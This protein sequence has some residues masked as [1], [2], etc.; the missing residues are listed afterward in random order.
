[1]KIKKVLLT[2]LMLA[3]I[4]PSAVMAGGKK[5][6]D[7]GELSVIPKKTVTLTVY[8]QLANYSGEQVG[9]FA[10][11]M[12]DKFNV[13]LNI[14]NNEEGIF[15]TR[16]A[17]GD[18]GDIVIFGS[19]TDE[20][21]Q[22]WQAGLLWEWNDENLLEDYGP[23]IADNMKLPLE[24]NASI[25]GGNLYGFAH[26]VA[27][28]ADDHEPFFYHPDIRWDLY[29]K[30]GYPE[31]NTLEDYIDVLEDMVELQPVSDTG[32]KTYGASLF[33]DWD[34]DMVMFVK[35]TAALYGWDE[36]GFGLYNADTD[37]YQDLFAKD[38]IYLRCLK[39]YN[40]L[41]QRGLLDPDSM[42]QNYDMHNEKYQ[43][44]AAFFVIFDWMGSGTYNSD[45]HKAE[46]RAMLPRP[47]NDA[48][49]ISY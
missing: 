46:G 34:G 23:Y 5:E 11:V 35:S 6:A 15:T 31:I 21:Q 36:F 16:M 3:V 10:Q 45:A 26:N 39:F 32:G 28:S 22:A 44:G 27:S 41:N 38:S 43:K 47:A 8:T 40:E 49:T 25:S 7:N 9:W 20:Y 37:E 4:L 13:K 17:S 14:V 19:D 2:I 12:K 24:K 48:K 30:L 33:S 42:T 18:L 1:M 29:K